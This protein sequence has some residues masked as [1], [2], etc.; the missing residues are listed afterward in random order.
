[1]NKI[2]LTVLSITLLLAG[3]RVRQELSPP[4]PEVVEI[5]VETPKTEALRILQQMKDSMPVYDWAV[6]RFSAD[7]TGLDNKRIL[8]G[9]Q[10]RI[11][12]DSAIW[13]SLSPAVGIEVARAI[14]THDSLRFLSRL[15]GSYYSGPSSK[16]N[17]LLMT[18]VDYNVLEALLLGNDFAYYED[19]VFSLDNS[20]RPLYHLSTP[21]RRKL[22]RQL[23]SS[24]TKPTVLIQDMWIDPQNYRITRQQVKVVGQES[25]KL[26]VEYS[27]FKRIDGKLIPHS[28]NLKITV[29][30]DIL[31]KIN[32]SRVELDVEQ[33]MPFSIPSSYKALNF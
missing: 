26:E 31:L 29:N 10:M 16:L 2:L 19:S 22:S 24:G 18:N 4:P 28:L 7:Y 8:V 5:P 9:G 27:D 25:Q 11:R 21:G 1:M 33:S 30:G 23:S 12:R 17:Q 15:Q 3:C 13:V 6:M 20:A 32:L 14:L